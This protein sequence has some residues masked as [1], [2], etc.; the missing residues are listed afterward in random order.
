M[1]IDSTPLGAPSFDVITTVPSTAGRP[2]HHPLE[3]LVANVVVGAAH[4]CEDLLRV[5]RAEL[6]A[7]SQA[8]DRY[9]AARDLTG[10]RVLV[11]DDTCTTGAHAQSASCALKSAGASAIG[12]SVFGAL[13]R[14]E[15]SSE[16]GVANREAQ[17]GLAVDHVL[18]PSPLKTLTLDSQTISTWTNSRCQ[19][20]KCRGRG[21]CTGC[22]V[23]RVRPRGRAHRA[24]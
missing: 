2:G 14:P 3:D 13:V 20:G 9:V 4:R 7:R 21:A 18:Y 24:W 12:V 19:P 15:L 16:L 10:V 1:S 5:Q 6:P 17:S 23:D 22:R 8:P 11:I